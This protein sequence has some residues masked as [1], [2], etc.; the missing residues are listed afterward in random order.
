MATVSPNIS[1]TMLN[2]IWDL[3]SS[4]IDEKT[5][6]ADQKL[7]AAIATADRVDVKIDP[8]A[9]NAARSAIEAMD[10]PGAPVRGNPGQQADQPE[11]IRMPKA[12][13]I[14]AVEPHTLGA[15]GSMGEYGA[16]PVFDSS[17][18]FTLDGLRNLYGNERAE[19]LA[20]MKRSFEQFIDQ[21]FPPGGYFDKATEW[22]E[23]ALEANGTG[24]PIIVESA[25]WERDRAR[26]TGEAAR[27]EDEAMTTWASRG[28]TLPP[29]ALVHGLNTIRAGLT[30][31]LS[32]QSRDIAIK[33]TDV[34]IENARFAVTNAAQIRSQALNA[35]VE[36]IKSLMVSPQYIGQW[37]TALIDGQTKMVGAQADVYRTRAGVATDVFKVGAQTELEKFKT[38][39]D[40]A[41]ESAK[42]Q[43]STDLEVYRT[44]ADVEKLKFTAD[45]EKYMKSEQFRLENFKVL[46]EI[47]LRHFEAEA[48]AA[49]LKGEL[50][51]RAGELAVR[52]GEAN[53]KV[54]LDTARMKVEAAMEA[55]KMVA[56]QCAAALNNMQL[57]ASAS[58]QSTTSGR[59]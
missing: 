26:L 12:P 43:N 16:P 29:G 30:N 53:A 32:T 18:S 1:I 3:L 6:A 41:L 48:R 55:A 44:A 2:Q 31:A 25:M 22:L 10:V 51:T 27:A 59:M 14:T 35:A 17:N 11:A 52:V 7:D 5:T 40:V 21:Y 24:I 9:L 8:S 39:S 19:M 20:E 49:T 47:S 13:I 4:I 23:R 34:H 56:T 57:S 50:M 42:N 54:D 46:E 36:Y 45:L 28:Y 58:N 38:T 33:V 37:L 15:F